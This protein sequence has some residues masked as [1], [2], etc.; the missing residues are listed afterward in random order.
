M[1]VIVEAVVV[2][3]VVVVVVVFIF[4]TRAAQG[5]LLGCTVTCKLIV[6]PLDVPALTTSLL[7]EIRAGRGGI[8]YRPKD[9]P[10]LSTSSALLRPLSRES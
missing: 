7:Y 10:T 2:I 4:T 5:I 3:V 8:I 1:A 6:P 9:V